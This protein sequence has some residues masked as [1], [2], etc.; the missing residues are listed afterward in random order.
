MLLKYHCENAE[1]RAYQ[2]G[3]VVFPGGDIMIPSGSYCGVRRPWTNLR[4]ILEIE[5]MSFT[6]VLDTGNWEVKGEKRIKNE[7]WVFDQ[8]T[9]S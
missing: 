5:Q 4:Y 6:D 2:Q 9:F 8:T 1:K 7:F 3:I